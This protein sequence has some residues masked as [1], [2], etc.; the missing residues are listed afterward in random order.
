MILGSVVVEAFKM[1]RDSY[2]M[3]LTMLPEVSSPSP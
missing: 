2:E 3:M 1:M